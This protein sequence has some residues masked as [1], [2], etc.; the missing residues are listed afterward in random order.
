[1]HNDFVSEKGINV[2]ISAS[3]LSSVKVHEVSRACPNT[4]ELLYRNNDSNF[5]STQ[6]DERTSGQ[7]SNEPANS[8]NVDI[9]K[10]RVDGVESI[11]V[12]DDL[13]QQSHSAVNLDPAS[14]V[15]QNELSKTNESSP[16][17]DT[18]S[19]AIST[20]DKT[21]DSSSPQQGAP[22]VSSPPPKSSWASLFKGTG[23]NSAKTVAYVEHL[24]QDGGMS[25]TEDV[26]VTNEASPQPPCSAEV[27][28]AMK[29]LG[30][31]KNMHVPYDYYKQRIH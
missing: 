8:D 28:L 17:T 12:S 14:L 18:S 30:G 2:V 6:S 4:N 23:T 19:S 25:S 26:N 16:A 9:N 10:S 24:G 31:E 1:M 7:I 3:H 15:Q 13:T 20:S 11:P 27:N 5:E 21:V 22:P 29:Q